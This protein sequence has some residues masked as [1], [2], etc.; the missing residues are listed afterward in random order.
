MGPVTNMSILFY[1]V[2]A[3]FI[4]SLVSLVGIAFLFRSSASYES[5]SKHMV[6]FAAGVLIATAFMNI[7][8]EALHE[9][10]TSAILFITLMGIIFSF[11]MERFVLW[12]HHHHNDMHNIKPSAYLV[13]VGDTIHN[14]IDG[15]A[16]AATF[17]VSVPLG[18]ITTLAII[19]HELPQ[20]IADFM[21]LVRSG[22][23]RQKAL[24][25]NFLTALTAVIGGVIGVYMVNTFTSALPFALA[26]TAGIFIYISAADLIPELHEDH[27]RNKPIQQ[28]IP[29]LFG[30]ALIVLLSQII[31]HT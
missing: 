10:E 11:L 26:L 27:D 6:S 7:L 30:I 24:M 28:V 8:S 31:P 14:F 4:T 29:F 21:I 17:S 2:V 3:S 13:I 22:F 25:Y 5:T 23:S 20:E 9:G 1:T 18:I 15:I 12:Y 19:S 16:I